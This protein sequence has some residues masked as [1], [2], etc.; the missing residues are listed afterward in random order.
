MM[1]QHEPVPCRRNCAD[2][3]C[4]PVRRPGVRCAPGWRTRYGTV[5]QV[6]TET[7]PALET[8]SVIVLL[9]SRCACESAHTPPPQSVG[10]LSRLAEP[11][12]RV[13]SSRMMS[14]LDPDAVPLLL[15]TF[16][17]LTV[18]SSNSQPIASLFGLAVVPATAN[19]NNE[20]IGL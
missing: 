9:A 6:P 19:P 10:P 1:R 7:S 5:T 18:S 13:K 16:R 4:R 14:R 12:V 15:R 17:L 11:A 20:A 8:A 3:V 2:P